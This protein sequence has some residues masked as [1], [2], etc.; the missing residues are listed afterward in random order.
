LV[1]VKNSP[2]LTGLYVPVS[3][4]VLAEMSKGIFI[5]CSKFI[6]KSP[7][8]CFGLSSYSL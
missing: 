4:E 1:N 7:E 3:N 2:K 6:S 5:D 8:S